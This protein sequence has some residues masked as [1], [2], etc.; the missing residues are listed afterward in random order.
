MEERMII[1]GRVADSNERR[2]R[3]NVKTDWQRLK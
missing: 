1:P 2:K 3:S